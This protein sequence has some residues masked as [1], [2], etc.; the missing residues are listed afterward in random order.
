MKKANLLVLLTFLWI[1]TT[2]EIKSWENVYCTTASGQ[3]YI[4]LTAV[5]FTIGANGFIYSV[6][7]GSYLHDSITDNDLIILKIDSLGNLISEK[8]ITYDSNSV[9]VP[10]AIR[11]NKTNGLL[12]IVSNS[13]LNDSINKCFIYGLN[14]A[15]DVDFTDSVEVNNSLLI[16]C[17]S[18]EIDANGN[19][20]LAGNYTEVDNGNNVFICKFTATH[21][22]TV[23]TY[24]NNNSTVDITAIKIAFDSNLNILMLACQNDIAKGKEWLLV[25]YS[26]NL[27]LLKK[28]TYN[29]KTNLYLD[30]IPTAITVA[31]N[32]DVYITGKSRY[33]VANTKTKLVT[34]K[35]NANFK[36][37]WVNVA[38]NLYTN[39]R[40]I[41]YSDSSIFISC[42]N[43]KFM[44]LSHETGVMKKEIDLPG[45]AIND[46][47]LN[48]KNEIIAAGQ[49]DTVYKKC[50]TYQG[51]LVRLDT[52][53]NV[54]Y[55]KNLPA[56]II[57]KVGYESEYLKV[58]PIESGF[59]ILARR[60]NSS[61]LGG[62][63]MKVQLFSYDIPKRLETVIQNH[64]N[65]L[66][67]MPNPA[68]ASTTISFSNPQDQNIEVAVFN[69]MGQKI[70][71]LQ[72][73]FLTYGDYSIEWDL[74]TDNN[75][76]LTNGVY[77]V[78]LLS[79]NGITTQ[80]V[81]VNK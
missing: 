16:N 17:S 18:I 10:V 68:A 65:T 40:Q 38:S 35:Y 4:N 30:D 78:Q 52:G 73:G 81:E 67:V 28:I 36:K 9:D 13:Q 19:T 14:D 31:T 69:L 47:K 43:F 46:F 34:V 72:S 41:S 48:Y 29:Y 59:Y 26:T 58:I 54:A 75:Y 60:F 27:A 7:Y 12:Y 66:K 44:V 51:Y 2:A 71:T 70:K 56:N 37:I 77:V 23:T 33:T 50:A 39:S 55:E 62:Y 79:S 32:N 21:T 20:I 5:D 6:G 22:K 63:C 57:K 8:I 45:V 49:S 24:T 25:K 74:K 64:S 1:T 76:E 42:D 15:L 61:I 53:G 11:F 3:N 80:K